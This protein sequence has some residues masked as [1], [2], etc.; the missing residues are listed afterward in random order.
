MRIDR[1]LMKSYRETCRENPYLVRRVIKVAKHRLGNDRKEVKRWVNAISQYFLCN[2]NLS[3]SDKKR[4]E[5]YIGHYH[6]VFPETKSE[7]EKVVDVNGHQIEINYNPESGEL[8]FKPVGGSI[9]DITNA[10]AF[11]TMREVAN[12]L[13]DIA[14]KK[15]SYAT[16][17]GSKNNIRDRF[18]SRTLERFGYILVD[19]HIGIFPGDLNSSIWERKEA[20]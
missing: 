13:R 18:Y 9:D 1:K 7:I 3:R 16:G 4:V 17:H 8:S 2:P 15:I 19:Q 11:A 10:G 6:D 20:E 5:E 12:A 14:P